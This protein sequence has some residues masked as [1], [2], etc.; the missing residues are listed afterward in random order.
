MKKITS[1]KDKLES[2]SR[3][4]DIDTSKK[5]CSQSMENATQDT[6]IHYNL[7]YPGESFSTMKEIERQLLKKKSTRSENRKDDTN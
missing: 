1:R 2:N 5:E 6:K 4:Q 3:M 7:N